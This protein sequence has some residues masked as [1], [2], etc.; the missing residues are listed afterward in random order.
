MPLIN[1]VVNWE[2]VNSD[3]TKPIPP[4][5]AGR[6]LA[7]SNQ[8]MQELMG[9]IARWRDTLASLGIDDNATSIQLTVSD[10]L[11]TFAGNVDVTGNFT[12]QGISDATVAGTRL[13]VSD[14]FITIDSTTLSRKIV[15]PDEL[16]STTICAGTNVGVGKGS[17]LELNAGSG[18][19]NGDWRAIVNGVTQTIWDESVGDFEI[20][21]GSGTKASNLT[22]SGGAGLQL[23]TFANAVAIGAGLKLT[24]RADHANTPAAT[25]GE[26]WLRSGANQGL[27]FTTDDTLD[28][29]L[30]RP[31]EGFITGLIMSPDTDTAHDINITP[32]RAADSTG[33]V[34]IELTSEIT[35]QIDVATGWVVGNDQAG[36]ADAVVLGTNQWIHVYLIMHADGTVDAGFD[37]SASASQLLTDSGY[38]Y[39]RRIGSV[40][41]DG[42]SNIIDFDCYDVSGTR[43]FRWTTPPADYSGV[44]ST[45]RALTTLSTPTGVRTDAVIKVMIQAASGPSLAC[46]FR[47]YPTD[48]LDLALSA[49]ATTVYS[50]G[51]GF[52][53]DSAVLK[54]RTDTNAQVFRDYGS[55]STAT[56]GTISALGWD[57]L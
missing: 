53:A 39:Y 15:G 29:D 54:I 12:S 30:I 56:T 10:S 24:E 22:L 31:L 28:H 41:T 16:G 4:S 2:I 42:S 38:T 23:A 49:A 6:T 36:L 17:S 57:E 21:T 8:S 13:T 35:K 20:L 5:P 27:M 1:E 34:Y 32:G 14:T 3:N 40:K 7:R 11:S 45:T 26:M 50:R 52:M 51:A 37:N 48:G 18:S 47:V 9:A 33:T 25:F 44:P 55:A 19:N 43:S 46:Y